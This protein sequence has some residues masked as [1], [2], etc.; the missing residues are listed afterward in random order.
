MILP[1][2]DAAIRRNQ[3]MF[4]FRPK[5]LFILSI[6]PGLLIFRRGYRARRE[7]RPRYQALSQ[8]LVR[9]EEFRNFRAAPEGLA[10][11]LSDTRQ[12]QILLCVSSAGIRGKH[13]I[14]EVWVLPSS[15]S[16]VDGPCRH[17]RGH[18]NH[19][20]RGAIAPRARFD[21]CVA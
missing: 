4:L 19:H 2:G 6:L 1:Y 7:A 13:G 18:V 20:H 8:R 17:G 16:V 9:L 12:V 21:A 15:P 5:Y 14:A 10:S 11:A 3:Q